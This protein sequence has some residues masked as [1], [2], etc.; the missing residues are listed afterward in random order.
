MDKVDAL[1]AFCKHAKTEADKTRIVEAVKA[2]APHYLQRSMEYR[3]HASTWL[4]KRRYEESPEDMRPGLSGR[5]FPGGPSTSPA[6]DLPTA[7]EYLRRT[8]QM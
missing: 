4:N 6:P 1:T 3:P 7:E 5:A 8:G 2:H